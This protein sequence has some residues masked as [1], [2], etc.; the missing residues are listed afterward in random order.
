MPFFQ[1]A[2]I[3]THTYV[4]AR[5]SKIEVRERMGALLSE[6]ITVVLERKCL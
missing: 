3:H 2:C 6:W 4:H 1:G 5:G